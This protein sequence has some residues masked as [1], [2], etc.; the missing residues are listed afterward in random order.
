VEGV[1]R[2]PEGGIFMYRYNLIVRYIIPHFQ[3]GLYLVIFFLPPAFANQGT[4]W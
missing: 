4:S 2:P 1:F 3:A